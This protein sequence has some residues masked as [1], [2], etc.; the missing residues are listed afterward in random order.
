[1]S[2]SHIE[3]VDGP[4]HVEL[5][6]G[7]DNDGGSRDEGEKEEKAEVDHHIAQEPKQTL[8]GQILPV[9]WDNRKQQKQWESLIQKGS[10][11]WRKQQC[12]LLSKN[13]F[14]CTVGILLK[15]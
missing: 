6:Y 7:V 12:W 14:E 5:V 1:M 8:H 4:S 9:G 2:K 3:I 15:R 10:A 13:V 11:E